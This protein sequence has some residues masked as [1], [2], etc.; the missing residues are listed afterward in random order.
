MYVTAGRSSTRARKRSSLTL[1]PEVAGCPA[2]PGSS[3]PRPPRLNPEHG[4]AWLGSRRDGLG[5]ELL[6]DRDVDRV[7][8]REHDQRR[9]VERER[10]AQAPAEV[11]GRLAAP[12]GEPEG[13][14]QLDE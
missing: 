8:D 4:C 1:A 5:A 12:A 7:V 9:H 13:V 10:M 6:A 11:L 14:R 2:I 3:A